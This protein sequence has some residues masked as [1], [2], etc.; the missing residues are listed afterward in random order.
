MYRLILDGT[1][2]CDGQVAKCDQPVHRRTVCTLPGA[3][4]CHTKVVLRSLAFLLVEVPIEHLLIDHVAASDS[5]FP[6]DTKTNCI[7]QKKTELNGLCSGEHPHVTR[8]NSSLFHRRGPLETKKGDQI[9]RP[10]APV[11]RGL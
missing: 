1:S 10:P 8:R 9:G 4:P 2:P 5:I 3:P 6:C 7:R 11:I